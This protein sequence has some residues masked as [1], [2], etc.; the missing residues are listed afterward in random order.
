M[1]GIY[2]YINLP[3]HPN[4]GI[5]GASGIEQKDQSTHTC[6]VWGATFRSSSR[7]QRMRT[8][9]P[10]RPAP[11]NAAEKPCGSWASQPAENSPASVRVSC[12]NVRSMD[13]CSSLNGTHWTTPLG[14]GGHALH[15]VRPGPPHVSPGFFLSACTPAAAWSTHLER[16]W[17]LRALDPAS[18]AK[19]GRMLQQ[20]QI[21]DT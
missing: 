8:L 16:A 19:L 11:P 2:A 3:N 17:L 1:H 5:H 15:H 21:H 18:L 12:P 10:N 20:V 13:L 7:T 14:Q 9:F 4:V 6:R